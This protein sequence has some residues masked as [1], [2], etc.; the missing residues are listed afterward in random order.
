MPKTITVRDVMVTEVYTLTPSMDI[1]Y[2]MRQ[3]LEKN[4]SGAPVLD[5]D[6]VVIGVLSKKDCLRAALNAH[7][8]QVSGGLVE[9]YMIEPVEFIDCDVELTV[10]AQTFINSR[11]RR[12]PVIDNGKLIG[13]VSRSDVLLALCDQWGNSPAP[14]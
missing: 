8:H 7:Y 14:N 11:Y 4:I 12:F 10:A 6:G 1:L 3:L 2:A 13:Q 9:Q 5:S